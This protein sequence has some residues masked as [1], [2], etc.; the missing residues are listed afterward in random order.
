[1]RCGSMG[2]S[3]EWE[4]TNQ[5]S[6]VIREVV[7]ICKKGSRSCKSPFKKVRVDLQPGK[8]AGYRD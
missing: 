3:L 6:I 7:G 1:M 8:S 4:I 2:E 5:R